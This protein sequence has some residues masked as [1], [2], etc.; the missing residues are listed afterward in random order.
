M[1]APAVDALPQLSADDFRSVFRGHAASVVVVTLASAS[2]PVGFTATSL[3]SVSLDPPLISFS[4]S[5]GS[6]SWPALADAWTVSV[7]LLGEDQA[8][9]ARR[10]ATSGIDRFA[11]PVRWERL[12]TG[13]PVLLDAPVSLQAHIVQQVPA[14]DHSIVIAEVADVIRRHQ[15]TPLVYHQGSY[16]ALAEGHRS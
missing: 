16:T 10:F 6:S 3:T 12:S 1:T 8:H 9:L 2:G 7:N 5:R 4:L 11:A 13:E 15:A 14:G